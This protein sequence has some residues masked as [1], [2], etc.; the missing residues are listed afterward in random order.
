M[1]RDIFLK[2]LDRAARRQLDADVARALHDELAGH[3]DAAIQA[4]LELGE[5]PDEAETN[6]VAA[7]GEPSRLVAGF[8][9]PERRYRRLHLV[10]I[11]ATFLVL[12]IQASGKIVVPAL[13]RGLTLAL[14]F[15]PTFVGLS[16]AGYYAF[17][18]RGIHFLGLAALYLPITAMFAFAFAPTWVPSPNGQGFIVRK[19]FERTIR[20]LEADLDRP[21]SHEEAV[22]EAYRELAAVNSDNVYGLPG[23]SRRS[24]A[25]RIEAYDRG[26]RAWDQITPQYIEA[27]KNE[28]KTYLA[29][30]RAN[31]D[32]PWAMNTLALLNMVYAISAVPFAFFVMISLFAAGLG[33]ICSRRRWRR[34]SG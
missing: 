26:E 4:R 19:D 10:A 14:L 24:I 8:G 32:R 9:E 17:R 12:A 34:A 6:A 13:P 20:S 5:T 31:Y 23:N 28:K 11:A 29:A 3:L 25:Q 21:R 15:S 2:E 30:W 18:S 1:T 22:R 33:R 7:L 27:R 16:V